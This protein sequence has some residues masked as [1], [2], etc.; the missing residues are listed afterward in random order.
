MPT[1]QCSLI[2]GILTP[3]YGH[4]VVISPNIYSF[5]FFF[6]SIQLSDNILDIVLGQYQ[7]EFLS[8]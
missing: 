8:S 3:T 1:E 4:T 5:D 2:L 7:M 6:F